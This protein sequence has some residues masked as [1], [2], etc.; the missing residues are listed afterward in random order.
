MRRRKGWLI[1]VRSQNQILDPPANLKCMNRFAP[2]NPT[3]SNQFV[4]TSQM[5]HEIGRQ[6]LFI[7]LSCHVLL[8][9]CQQDFDHMHNPPVEAC[10]S[11]NSKSVPRA[12]ESKA[13]NK[14]V[15]R[16]NTEHTPAQW[17]AIRDELP[18]LVKSD[19]CAFEA[20]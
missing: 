17:E 20:N 14:T 15:K 6:H 2:N 12:H 7:V 13:I 1:H 8:S 5:N 3:E 11:K 10:S 19:F 9:A 16:C 18:A 4:R